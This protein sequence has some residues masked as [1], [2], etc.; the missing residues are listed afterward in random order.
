[1]SDIISPS[2]CAQQIHVIAIAISAKVILA[3]YSP[4]K[5]LDYFPVTN[6]ISRKLCYRQTPL[7]TSRRY[8]VLIITP[9]LLHH[10]NIETQWFQQG[11]SL[12]VEAF[13]QYSDN[14]ISTT[15]KFTSFNSSQSRE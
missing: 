7:G 13:G 14:Q 1:M 15:S 10:H 9:E 8:H 11:E 12:L 6:I 4:L 2:L 5:S 3:A